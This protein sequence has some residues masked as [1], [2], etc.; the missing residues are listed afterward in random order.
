MKSIF[1][2]ALQQLPLTALGNKGNRRVGSLKLDH[3]DIAKKK[4]MQM[5]SP[6][7]TNQDKKQ[8]MLKVGEKEMGCSAEWYASL[9]F[10]DQWH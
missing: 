2:H 6:I 10:P 8:I 7:V 3:K 5:W 4:G 9:T 1:D